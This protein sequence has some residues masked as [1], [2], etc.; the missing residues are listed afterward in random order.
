[1]YIHL[2]HSNHY[3]SKEITR[4]RARSSRVSSGSETYGEVLHI[5][6]WCDRVRVSSLIIQECR[7]PYTSELANA[8]LLQVCHYTIYLYGR[9]LHLHLAP[10]QSF[11]NE[12]RE[13]YIYI[14]PRKKIENSVYYECNV[15]SSSSSLTTENTR[16]GNLICKWRTRCCGLVDAGSCMSPSISPFELVQLSIPNLSAGWKIFF[17][18]KMFMM[19]ARFRCLR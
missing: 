9:E 1:M 7:T 13:R 4:C 16:V 19:E 5:E 12:E 3:R 17:H 6:R 10:S 15:S 18:S 11:G 2:G 14:F 8:Y